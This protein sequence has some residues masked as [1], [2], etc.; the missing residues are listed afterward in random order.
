MGAANSVAGIRASHVPLEPHAETAERH[1]R[2]W[3][4]ALERR[5]RTRIAFLSGG[6]SRSKQAARPSFF[7][8]DRRALDK[9][10]QVGIRYPVTSIR[11]SALTKVSERVASEISAQ[12]QNGVI[13]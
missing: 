1:L 2:I 12:R 10:Y 4:D 13:L 5:L 3:I 11:S 7:R 9:E 8:I 6:E